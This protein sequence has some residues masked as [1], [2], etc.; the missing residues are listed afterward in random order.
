MAVVFEEIVLGAW[1]FSPPSSNE[2]P[3]ILPRGRHQDFHHCPAAKPHPVVSV[4]YAWEV[5]TRYSDP[6]QPGR[7]QQRSSRPPL[8]YP[9]RLGEERGLEPQPSNGAV[10][11]FPCQNR[12]SE[13]QLMQR[14]E[15]RFHVSSPKPQNIRVSIQITCDP[16][17]KENVNLG[18]K[19]GQSISASLK[20]TERLEFCQESLSRL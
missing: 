9:Q 18:E 15:V 2:E 8:G 5:A 1:N 14:V 10:S 11:P 3:L 19:K 7:Y 4:E 12:V 6:S 17:N 20:M 13:I 16:K